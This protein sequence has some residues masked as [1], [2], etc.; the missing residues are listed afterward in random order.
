MPLLTHFKQA[1]ISILHIYLWWLR[2][3]QTL[4]CSASDVNKRIGSTFAFKLHMTNFQCKLLMESHCKRCGIGTLIYS[5]RCTFTEILAWSGLIE[6]LFIHVYDFMM[7]KQS[8]TSTNWITRWE[9]VRWLHTVLNVTKDNVQHLRRTLGRIYMTCILHIQHIKYLCAMMIMEWWQYVL[10]GCT[11]MND[12][13]YILTKM[14]L[15]RSRPA[16]IN[17]LQNTG[18]IWKR[19]TCQLVRRLSYIDAIYW[20]TVR[21]YFFRQGRWN[22]DRVRNSL[23]YHYEF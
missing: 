19:Q 4:K 15:K 17:R 16:I 12:G 20:W 11:L 22:D 23:L 7:I 5:K 6:W 8:S 21:Y 2:R 18:H 3:F 9:M 14:Y 10:N 13:L 1:L